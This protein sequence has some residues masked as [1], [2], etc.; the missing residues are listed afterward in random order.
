M[1]PAQ[2]SVDRFRF[3]EQEAY[4]QAALHGELPHPN[5][6][7]RQRPPVQSFIRKRDSRHVD[8]KLVRQLDDLLP[9]MERDPVSC[10]WRCLTR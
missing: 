4:W 1:T 8:A 2:E 9:A 7:D 6:A 3:S 10:S 5:L